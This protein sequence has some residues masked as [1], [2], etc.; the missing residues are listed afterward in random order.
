[1]FH[2][3]FSKKYN[4]DKL[5]NEI[6]A[7]NIPMISMDL[8]SDSEFI[9]N[10]AVEL[11]SQQL[12]TLNAIIAAHVTTTNIKDVVAARIMAARDFGMKLIAQYGAQ[13]VLS[14]YDIQQI[15]YIMEKTA[16]VQAALNT[17]SLYVAINE[18]N[19]IEPDGNLI[20]AEKIASFRNLIEDYLQIPRT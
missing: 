7:A 10:T 11:T 16:K 1:M 2:Y 20:T 13:N 19:A 9:V 6:A 4:L 15:Q 12:Q 3:K 18:L 14:G 8:I 17:G 5:N